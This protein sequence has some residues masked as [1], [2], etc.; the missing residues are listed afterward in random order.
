[1]FTALLRSQA[2]VRERLYELV[3]KSPRPILVAQEHDLSFGGPFERRM[4]YRHLLEHKAPMSIVVVADDGHEGMWRDPVAD[5]AEELFDDS[6]D[7][8]AAQSGYLLFL[9]NGR[10]SYVKRDIWDSTQDIRAIA[11]K[12]NL[13]IPVP[14]KPKVAEVR[15]RFRRVDDDKAPKKKR[16]RTGAFRLNEDDEQT[17]PAAEPRAK[18]NAPPPEPPRVD[19]FEVLG[20]A[21]S[22]S[23]DDVKKA[24]RALVVQYHPDKVAHL[25]PEFRV[26][27]EQK[28][29]ELTAAYEQ[30]QKLARGESLD[31]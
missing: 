15:P 23:E 24:F 5:L 19:P 14:E 18:R 20:L 1:V 31:G 26:L 12:L 8:A 4:P 22:A 7:Q 10:V 3:R 25:A 28:T 21:R 27:A 17:D 13:G 16:T 30:A 2:D 9:T 29:R 11:R 6:R